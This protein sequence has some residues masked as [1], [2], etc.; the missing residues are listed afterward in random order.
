[1][2]QDILSRYNSAE[3]AAD[4]TKKFERHWTERVNNWNEQR[5]LKRLLEPVAL[6]NS[7]APALDLPCG[8]GRLFSV[9]GD[10]KMPVIEGDWSFHLLSAAR[11]FHGRE[12]RTVLPAG[13]VR[14]TALNLPFKDRAFGL[15][16][17]VRLCHHI[18]EH[19]ERLQYLREIMRVSSKWLIFTYFDADSVKNRTH[20]FRRRF[21]GKRS[22]WTLGPREVL[23]LSRA[24]GFELVRSEWMSRFFSG[25]RYVL[26][27][28]ID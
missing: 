23:E 18:R 24:G 10:L 14:A 3:G 4:Y 15:V 11:F 17:S 1:M 27:R 8:Y 19:Q 26:M 16:L 6:E 20:E 21:N 2:D 13:Y 22:K 5:L 9:L 7:A 25:H 12:S 28:R